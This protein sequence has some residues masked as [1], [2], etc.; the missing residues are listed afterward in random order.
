MTKEKNIK[1]LLT[2]LLIISISVSLLA[3]REIQDLNKIA[4]KSK[5]ENQVRGLELIENEYTKYLDKEF[6]VWDEKE[7]WKTYRNEEYGFEIKYPEK[8]NEDCRFK[9]DCFA[10]S[11]WK[12]VEV[13]DF[14]FDNDKD[15]YS[16][17]NENKV[18]DNVHFTFGS[19]RTINRLIDFNVFEREDVRDNNYK[20]Q[21][22]SSLFVIGFHPNESNLPFDEF[23]SQEIL[24]TCEGIENQRVVKINGVEGYR[25]V[26]PP[27]YSATLGIIYYLPT[28]DNKMIIS[29]GAPIELFEEERALD[30]KL[31]EFIEIH[32]QYKKEIEE[33]ENRPDDS[34]WKFMQNNPDY[35]NFLDHFFVEHAR[36]ELNK[37]LLFEKI[38]YSFKFY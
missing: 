31:P 2:V 37:R 35:K 5:T 12:K 10:E 4:E 11:E 6:D 20:Y 21:V 38:V 36:K 28:Q 34:L 8:F 26:L 19:F 1:Y 18:S 30:A 24:N 33:M 16:G 14:K 32:P 3:W 15:F 13:R 7:K 9:I 17:Q 27:V 29:I 22:E 25:I 23:I